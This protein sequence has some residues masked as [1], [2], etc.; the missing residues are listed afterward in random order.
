MSLRLFLAVLIGFFMSMTARANDYGDMSGI[1][2]RS[3]VQ[4][5]HAYNSVSIQPSWEECREIG[6]AYQDALNDIHDIVMT[7]MN[8]TELGQARDLGRNCHLWSGP[9]AAR[10]GACTTHYPSCTEAQT[11]WYDVAVE[12]DSTMSMCYERAAGRSQQLQ[13]AQGALSQER[14]FYG[15]VHS[16]AERMIP[17]SSAQRI[18]RGQMSEVGKQHRKTLD[19]LEELIETLEEN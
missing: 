5:L 13:E 8:N 15:K 9:G 1:N 4:A 19:T 12:R 10:L 7:C 16:L 6:T 14:Q 17:Q 11:S 2:A 18:I 3:V